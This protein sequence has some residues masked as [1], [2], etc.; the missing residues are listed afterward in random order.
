MSDDKSKRGQPD[1]STIALSE[2]HEVAYWTKAL[3]VSEATVTTR[4]RTIP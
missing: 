1:R 3:G 4:M 2:P